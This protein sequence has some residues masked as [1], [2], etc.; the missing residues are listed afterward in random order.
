M[1]GKSTKLHMAIGAIIILIFIGFSYNGLSF[2]DSMERQIYD[3]GMRFTPAQDQGTGRIVL[4]DIDDT[5]IARLGEW[6]WPRHLI[7]EMIDILQRNKARLIGLNIPFTEK[8]TNQG[9]R[10]VKI[11]R[12]KYNVYPLA[13]KDTA[14][15]DWILDN[16]NQIE[17]RLDN[18]LTL[19]E[20][21]KQ[22]KNVILPVF[23]ISGTHQK[24]QK[25]GDDSSLSGNFLNSAKISPA[26]KE[27]ISVNSLA[28]P[29][30]ELAQNA[31]GLGHGN[32]TLE[33]D[34]D[35]RFHSIFISYKG[36]LLPSFPL[37]LA[38]AYLNQKPNQVLAEDNLLRLKDRIIP[39]TMG[40]MFI[41]FEDGQV[42]IPR[43]S[44]ADLLK[45]EKALP[46]VNGK[47][48][49]IGHN[50]TGSRQFDTPMS[51]NMPG[52]ELTAH[53]LANIIN[54]RHITRPSY[55]PYIEILI[56]FLIGAFA[57]F[58]FPRK[59]QLSRLIWTI[60]LILLPFI[61]GTVLLSVMSIWFKSAYVICCVAAIFL[62]VSARDLL[63]SERF[64]KESYETSRMLGLSFQ[65]Q[66]LLDLAYDKFRKLPLNN[67]A[68]DF[69]YSLGLE[70]ESKRM[71]NKALAAYDYI[72]KGGGFRDLDDRIPKLR[73]SDKS[74][75][76]G[77][78]DMAKEVSIVA[79]SE[80][81]IRSKVGR[82]EILEEIGKGSM[83]LVYKAQD[84]KINRLVAIKTI[85]FSDEFDEDVIQEIKERFFREA[86]IA[87]QLSHPSIVVIH[88]VG[89]DRDLTYMAMEFLEGEDLDK[90]IVKDNLLHFRRALDIVVRIA[91]ALDFAH[92]AEVIH[93]D[94]KPAN[95]MLLKNGQVK[96]TD[97]GIAKAISS[98]RTK[99]GVILGTPNYMSPEQIMGQKIDSRS[100]IFSLG[101][102]F[103]QLITG[104]L[105]FHGENLSGLLYQITQ[106]KHPSPREYKPKIPKVCEQIIDKALEKYPD[107]RFKTAGDMSKVIRLLSSKID[108]LR[109]E[110]AVN[111]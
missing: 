28:F 35:G 40:E 12:E 94:I 56:I 68:K 72:N 37:R 51:A 77:S 4:I 79:D 60:C 24:S 58:Y 5:S 53:I 46:V 92:K 49:L 38:M 71:I 26:L 34:M 66:G 111:Q 7:A 84:P 104:E 30:S 11:F 78:Y 27:R 65:S 62:Y 15:N 108:Q 9:L 73:Q 57:S 44:F 87:G 47:I 90:Y 96:V 76:L 42:K 21:V 25:S 100:D 103:Y 107:K 13:G 16:L 43:F 23:G 17:K 55:M 91:D 85:R 102:L 70:Y 83:G 29:F 36:S 88:D 54:N 110:R 61:A 64:A 14:L 31:S 6:P 20:S 86:E 18:D 98:S 63:S 59:K 8:E 52:S 2:V 3:L 75:T 67:E 22:S 80:T 99:T 74:S 39:I 106:V 33:N 101:V 41:K 19:V 48:I 45:T 97:F 82:Y 1:A 32:L 93:R 89:D 50:R 95:V 10:E 109:R 69:I 81:G 105:P